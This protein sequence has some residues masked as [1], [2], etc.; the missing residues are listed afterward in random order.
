MDLYVRLAEEVLPPR[1]GSG[2]PSSTLCGPCTP[3]TAITATVESADEERS[4]VL[5]GSVAP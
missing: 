5:L 1:Y 2:G 4:G 3:H